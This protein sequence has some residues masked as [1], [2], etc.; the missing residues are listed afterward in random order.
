MFSSRSGTATNESSVSRTGN[1]ATQEGAA[2]HI[3][4]DPA[5]RLRFPAGL[6][7]KRLLQ[8]IAVLVLLNCVT[9][10]ALYAVDYQV[11]DGIKALCFLVHLD[12]E[13]SLP[14]WYSTLALL[15]CT[16]L[17]A[18]IARSKY[19]AGDGYALHWL[20]LV[21]LFGTMSLDEIAC[22]HEL[23]STALQRRLQTGGV[24][25]YAWI[26]PGSI[27]VL[28][29]GLTYLKFLRHLPTRTRKLFILA[30]AV[31]FGGALGMEALSGLFLTGGS[32]E[33]F[34]YI[35]VS[36]IEE[37]CEMTGV[38][39]LIYALLDYLPAL[40]PAIRVEFS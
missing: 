28:I 8:I 5:L 27:F 37:A 34:G 15:F 9:R 23:T 26:I 39:L 1:L 19:R 21:L 3:A 6:T 29:V 17:L 31:Y 13:S 4:A 22:V 20:G 11:R 7:L 35:V 24:L 33:M 38:A 18:V 30:G 36:T 25:S 12:Y 10:F 2:H 16:L 40:V 32:G 14:T